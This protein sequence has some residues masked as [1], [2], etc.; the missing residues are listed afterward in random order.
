MEWLPVNDRSVQLLSVISSGNRMG[1]STWN[2]YLDVTVEWCPNTRTFK[3]HEPLES[4]SIT[5]HERATIQSKDVM[6]TIVCDPARFTVVTALESWCKIAKLMMWAGSQ[7]HFLNGGLSV[8]VAILKPDRP[9]WSCASTER[10]GSGANA[11]HSPDLA[12][13]NVDLSVTAW[14]TMTNGFIRCPSATMHPMS[15][16]HFIRRL[17]GTWT[18]MSG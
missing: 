9:C 11:P 2:E 17:T 8:R 18:E 1:Y 6:R 15:V 14:S 13:C 4:Y 7:Y 5:P 16:N 12:L 10:D 3:E